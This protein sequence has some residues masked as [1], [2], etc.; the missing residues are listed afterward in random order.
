MW[1]E[2]K[3]D[4]NLLWRSPRVTKKM[5][6]S[7]NKVLMY[8]CTIHNNFL[9]FNCLWLHLLL[10]PVFWKESKSMKYPKW[11]SGWGDYIVHSF[12][13]SWAY[14]IYLLPFLDVCDID[15]ELNDWAQSANFYGIVASPNLGYGPDVRAFLLVYKYLLHN[16]L[17]TLTFI[18]LQ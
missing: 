8:V 15:Q 13:S 14:I 7:F 9:N 12:P 4:V 18:S 5:L 10:W 17:I 1:I 6:F 11:G 16:I 2:D 3:Y